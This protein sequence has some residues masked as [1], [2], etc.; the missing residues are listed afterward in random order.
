MRAEFQFG[1][2]RTFRRW[3]WRWLHDNA[4]V[5]KMVKIIKLCIF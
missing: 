5:L 4:H 1:K 2:M 3:W